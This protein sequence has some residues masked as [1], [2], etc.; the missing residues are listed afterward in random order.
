MGATLPSYA[1]VVDEGG[2]TSLTAGSNN[3]IDNT[4]TN[5]DNKHS[6]PPTFGRYNGNKNDSFGGINGGGRGD[7]I[8]TC[9]F[10]VLQGIK[11]N[12][13]LMG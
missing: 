4:T 9:L 13:S 11:P 8:G 3:T 6:G 5:F 1:A 12:S 10:V 7:G 2:K